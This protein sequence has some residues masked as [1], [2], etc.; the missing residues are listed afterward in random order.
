MPRTMKAEKSTLAAE[1]T[2][3]HIPALT[4]AVGAASNIVEL[5]PL[6]A[7]QAADTKPAY[8]AD[9]HEKISVSL[10]DVRGGPAMHLLRSYKYKQMQVRFDREQPDERF[11]KMLTDAGWRDRTQEE[12]VFTKQIDRDAKWQSVDKMEK[13]FREVANAIREAKGLGPVL[14]RIGA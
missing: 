7:R 13:E 9:P 10:S 3:E 11:L 12:G 8:A 1:A 4:P 14:E 2:P 6:P 5:E